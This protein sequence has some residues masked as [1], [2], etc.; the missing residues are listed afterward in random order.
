MSPEVPEFLVRLPEPK[1][2]SYAEFVANPK[3]WLQD[4]EY[5]A[6]DI[7][8]VDRFGDWNR[9]P[10]GAQFPCERVKDQQDMEFVIALSQ[11]VESIPVCDHLLAI[12]SDAKF[13]YDP[14]SLIELYRIT[15]SERVKWRVAD[16]FRSTKPIR[17]QDFLREEVFA[18]NTDY[19]RATIMLAIERHLSKREQLEIARKMYSLQPELSIRILGK[20]GEREDLERLLQIKAASKAFRFEESPGDLKMA[21]QKL[22]KRLS[23]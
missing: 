18:Q 19:V 23:T 7:A 1:D 13:S 15:S 9:T 5:R 2:H 20:F 12:L 14:S 17:I 16:I 21:I 6:V 22:Q 11:M 10:L 8:L 3:K 4:R